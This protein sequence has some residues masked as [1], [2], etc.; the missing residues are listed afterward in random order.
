[1]KRKRDE[2]AKAERREGV[3]IKPKTKE[4]G[5]NGLRDSRLILTKS[6]VRATSPPVFV[7]FFTEVSLFCLGFLFLFFFFF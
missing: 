5:A 1:M 7:N 4:E 2:D 6:Q 3:N